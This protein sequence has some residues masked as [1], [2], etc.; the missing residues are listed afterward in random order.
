MKFVVNKN[1]NRIGLES[2]DQFIDIIL[3]YG[4]L[5]SEKE[6]IT[7]ME[8]KKIASK[9]IPQSMRDFIAL[10]EEGTLI[11]HSILSY[12]ESNKFNQEISYPIRGVIPGPPIV[13]PKDIICIGRNYYSNVDKAGIPDYPSWFLKTRSAIIGMHDQIIIPEPVQRVNHGTELAVII[14]KCGKNIL[15]KEAMNHV[16][17]Y[18]ILNDL[19]ADTRFIG[20][21]F[22]TSA[23]IGPR[24][25]TKEEISPQDLNLELCVN[26]VRIANGNTNNMIFKIPYLISFISSL[27]MLEPGDVIATG[28]PVDIGPLN[29]GD[30]VEAIIEGIGS[31]TNTVSSVRPKIPRP[32]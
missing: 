17:G 30:V 5:L 25:V 21:N 19:G 4:A 7:Q 14:G 28:T 23:P 11:A 32:K 8:A 9:K 15:E 2:E 1:K 24:I 12:I 13:P 10:G 31:L 18:T 26:T 3:A 27:L 29:P 6:G 22:F 16:F 20:K